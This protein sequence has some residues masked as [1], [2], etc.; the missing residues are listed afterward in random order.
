VPGVAQIAA[1]VRLVHPAPTM[2]VTALSGALGGILL[3]Q[4]GRPLDERWLWTIVA[5]FGSQVFVGASNDLV[6]RGRDTAAGRVSKPLAAGSLSPGAA[7]WIGSVGLAVQLAASLR[8]GVPFLLLG[9]VAVGSAL[10]YNLWLS[11]T[12]LSVAPYLISFGVLPLW[13]A[14]GVAVP[15]ERVAIAPLLVAPFAAAAH[16]A[17]VLRDFDA[18]AAQGSRNL[19]QLLGR[20]RAF[21]L[22]WGLALGVGLAVGAALL[23]GG[24]IHPLG[25]V[26]GLAGLVAIAQGAR[27][28]DALWIGML[29]AAVSWTAAW[30]LSTG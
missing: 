25:V 10:A 3:A 27:G 22:A 29:A 26:L 21:I 28:A 20:S 5:V 2:A 24:P 19:A 23:L 12:P 18:D 16:L 1:A 6:D 11:R 13:V 15:L 7:V 17:N 30:A 8:L 14:T 9:L 4:A